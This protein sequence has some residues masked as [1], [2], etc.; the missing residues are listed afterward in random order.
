VGREIFVTVDYT[1]GDYSDNDTDVA[2]DFMETDLQKY[3][4]IAAANTHDPNFLGKKTNDS[5]GPCEGGF[6]FK[7]VTVN[8]I[9]CYREALYMDGA[10]DNGKLNTVLTHC[11][12]HFEIGVRYTL[13]IMFGPDFDLLK[14][15]ERFKLTGK[16]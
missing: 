4:K 13:C 14:F 1:N 6:I 5:I 15:L 7:N 3:M 12:Y 16:K 11:F 9:L 2:K 10:T 8:S